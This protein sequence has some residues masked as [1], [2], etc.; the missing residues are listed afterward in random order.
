M[1]DLMNNIM[2]SIPDMS[3]IFITHD[4]SEAVYLTDDV[5][6]MQANPGCIVDQFEVDLPFERDRSLKKT[7]KFKNMVDELEDRMEKLAPRKNIVRLKKGAVAEMV[8]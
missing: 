3:I 7:T 6:I 4:I 5:Y 1:Q 8:K 2:V